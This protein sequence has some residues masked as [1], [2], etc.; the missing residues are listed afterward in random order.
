[1]TTRLLRPW[2]SPGESSEPAVSSPPAKAG[3]TGRVPVWEDP[4]AADPSRGPQPLK[5]HAWRPGLRAAGSSPAEGR[6]KE[7]A[8]GRK[9]PGQ[10][11]ALQTIGYRKSQSPL[12]T[13]NRVQKWGTSGRQ[14]WSQSIPHSPLTGRP[15]VRGPL[16]NASVSVLD[17]GRSFPGGPA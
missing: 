10:P 17:Q 1:M 9:E 12:Q 5:P 16:F 3:D 14:S 7:P 4:G 8:R 15:A 6:E 13:E 2:G 11:S